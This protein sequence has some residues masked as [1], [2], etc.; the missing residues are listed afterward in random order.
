MVKRY[1]PDKFWLFHG[2]VDVGAHLL[3]LV[4]GF[5][6]IHFEGIPQ[7][8]HARQSALGDHRQVAAVGLAHDL[9]AILDWSPNIHNHG[10][11]SHDL[12]ERCSCR[13]EAFGNDAVEHVPFREDSDQPFPL[14]YRHSADVALGHVAAGLQDSLSGAHEVHIPAA[15]LT[16]SGHMGARVTQSVKLG[17]LIAGLNQ[18]ASRSM[19]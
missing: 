4:G 14:Q 18:D 19:A 10:V 3:D 1:G 7:G 16:Q 6:E 8:D 12:G 2:A 11:G 17:T 13:I 5:V 9:K 15:Q